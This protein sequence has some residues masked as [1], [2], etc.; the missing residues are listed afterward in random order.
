MAKEKPDSG[1]FWCERSITCNGCKHLN[2][3]KGGCKRNM[4]PGEVRPLS[5]YKNGDGYIAMLKPADCTYDRTKE[6]A[7]A[8][9]DAAEVVGGAQDSTARAS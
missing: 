4:P 5:T 2:F 6:R 7:V 9:T 3:K 8:S 1:Y